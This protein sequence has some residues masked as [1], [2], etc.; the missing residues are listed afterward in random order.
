MKISQEKLMALLR[1]YVFAASDDARLDIFSEVMAGY[2]RHC[3]TN[4]KNC[5]CWNDE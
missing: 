4:D 2:C 5:F 3:G 1:A